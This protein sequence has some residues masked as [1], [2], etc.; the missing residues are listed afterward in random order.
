M[1]NISN[2]NSLPLNSSNKNILCNVVSELQLI[3]CG[4]VAHTESIGY[5][6]VVLQL[7]QYGYTGATGISAEFESALSVFS[8]S[9]QA[10]ITGNFGDFSLP[11]CDFY[12]K[13]ESVN[14]VTGTAN[15][16]FKSTGSTFETTLVTCA[17]IT[18]SIV[19]AGYSGTASITDGSVL[20]SSI[21]IGGEIENP[22]LCAFDCS[23]GSPMANGNADVAQ[24]GQASVVIHQLVSN[25]AAHPPSTC[26]GASVFPFFVANGT[27]LKP[28]SLSNLSHTNG[29]DGVPPI[30]DSPQFYPLHHERCA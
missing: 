27:T 24:Y 11:L 14:I 20:F 16:S 5:G 3:E 15:V 13:A 26:V 17:V 12:G 25:G 6:D 29:C 19:C 1:L 2:I 9:G 8:A 30:I 4:G 10:S 18:P 23:L 7:S 28:F 21:V 22:A